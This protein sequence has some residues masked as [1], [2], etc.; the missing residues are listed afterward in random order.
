MERLKIPTPFDEIIKLHK[1]IIL[2]S[3]KN[4]LKEDL[5]K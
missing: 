1:K 2:K 4:K 3:K 5:K